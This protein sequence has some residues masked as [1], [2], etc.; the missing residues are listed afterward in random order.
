MLSNLNE[1]NTDIS[2]DDTL[3][4]SRFKDEGI[5]SAEFIFDLKNSFQTIKISPDF[6]IVT[7]LLP[8]KN[9][10]VDIESSVRRIDTFAKRILDTLSNKKL[11][12]LRKDYIKNPIFGVGQLAF[13]NPFPDEF[14]YE[15]KFMKAYLASY[16]NELFSINIR[17]EHWITGGIQTYV[18]MQYVEEFY[19]GS[20]FLGDL[21]K[22][23][24]LGIRPFNSY[25]SLIHIS[26]PTRPY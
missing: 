16:L 21:Y 24:I 14:I 23:K 5:S 17:K 19:S 4:S 18:M 3:K 20:K 25:L 7:D 8:G 26:E 9:D 15:T 12:V 6:I 22:F 11:L 13:L 1:I 2:S 10:E